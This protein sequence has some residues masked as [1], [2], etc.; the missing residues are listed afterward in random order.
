MGG[1]TNQ[2]KTAEIHLCDDLPT[3]GRKGGMDYG[4]PK[5]LDNT[6]NDR[7]QPTESAFR[8]R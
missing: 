1:K 5:P 3:D 7:L 4:Q 8:T 2:R 6:A